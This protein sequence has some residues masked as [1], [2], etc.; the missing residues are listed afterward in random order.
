MSGYRTAKMD[1][2]LDN[3]GRPVGFK[4]ADSAEYFFAPLVVGQSGV[5]SSVTGTTAETV[6]AQVTIPGGLLGPNG[7]IRVSPLFAYNN[8]GNIKTLKVK[9]GG[10]TF[11]SLTPTTTADAQPPT[12]HIRNAGTP[13]AQVAFETGTNNSIGP[14]P[15]VSSAVNTALDQTVQITGQLASAAETITLL[16]YI[17]EVLPA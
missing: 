11:Y 9:F 3:N 15:Y 12:V 4:A 14:G 2:L 7:I 8:S 10:T 6:L 16:G 13:N 1:V 5:A 17:V